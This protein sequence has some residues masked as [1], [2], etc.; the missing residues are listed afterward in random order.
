MKK[1]YIPTSSLN[2]N[3]IMSSESISPKA[4][5]QARSFGYGRWISI[6]ENPYENSVVLY[7]QLCSFT[8]PELDIE[9]HSLIIEVTL[10]DSVESN[11]IAVNEHMFLSDHTI[12]IDPFSTNLYFFNETDM[13]I[14]LSMS[15]SSIETKFV[16]LYQNRIRVI[17]SSNTTYQLPDYSS[18]KQKFNKSEVEKDRSI[19]RMKG[20]LYGYY[21][22]AILSSS[23]DS[24]VRLNTLREIH[25]ILVAILASLDHK[26]TAQQRERLK[27]LYSIIQPEIPF[28]SKLSGLV[29]DKS[30]LDGIVAL[31]RSEYGHF[32]GEYNVENIISQ[33]LSVSASK[34]AKNPIIEQI[35]LFISQTEKTIARNA[36][37][38]PV[39]EGQILVFDNILY[40]INISD[41]SNTDKKLYI[42]WINEVLSKDEYTGKTSTFKD[43][44]SDDVTRK[45]KEVCDG[46]WKG[47]YPEVTLNALRRHVRGDEFPHLWSNDIYSAMSSL[48]IR[49]DDWQKL[50]Q[51]MQAKEM[52]DYRI[53]FSMYGT[54]N[55]F[56]NLPRDFT[57]VMFRC[58]IRYI[59]EVYKEFYGQ[60]FGRAVIIPESNMSSSVAPVPL[61]STDKYM[62]QIS[63]SRVLSD[64]NNGNINSS[65]VEGQSIEAIL[66]KMKYGKRQKKSLNE[67]AVDIICKLLVDCNNH[68]T[69]Y[70]YD[71]ISKIR[72]VG[73]EAVM[74]LKDIL[75]MAA[76]QEQDLFGQQT[77]PSFV[78]DDEAINVVKKMRIP[79]QKIADILIEDIKYIQSYHRNDSPF[80]NHECISHLKNLVFSDKCTIPL[81]K[82]PENIKIVDV[83]ID[84]LTLLY[85][86]NR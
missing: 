41:L 86:N 2:F 22:G 36:K 37:P 52:T 9:D 62:E 33:L 57:D 39:D 74:A 31:L 38:V 21:I 12:Y 3:N 44:L 6:P 13:R 7:D 46:E 61:H 50:L 82:T 28:L 17:V 18:E 43:V 80:D 8:R 68:P 54:I 72:G 29:S 79:D 51:Y 83:L 48:I 14:A 73:D 40:R 49:G 70:F 81:I 63:S 15:D 45:A 60:L 27:Y 32:R 76:S 66:K 56:A 42:A 55:G 71:K 11:L 47:S 53:P 26:A 64:A 10:D 25:D 1:Y 85:C 5:Y 65:M 16:Q 59:E 34:V 67:N 20:L 69:K 23:K 78:L 75:G 30:L 84:K 77:I 4:F 58:D 35:N 24:I 19:N